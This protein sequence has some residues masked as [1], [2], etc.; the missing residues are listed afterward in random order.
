MP[1]LTSFL[2]MQS[3]CPRILLTQGVFTFL[4]EGRGRGK[5]GSPFFQALP[6]WMP[7]ATRPGSSRP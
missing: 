4:G 2:D 5:A 7:M 6:W 3:P 1:G